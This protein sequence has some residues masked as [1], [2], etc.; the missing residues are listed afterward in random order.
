MNGKSIMSFAKGMGAGMVVAGAA[1]VVGKV[2]MNNNKNLAK[3][4]SKAIKAVSDF[5]D[6]VQTIFH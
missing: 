2:M 1:V 5:V 3:G 6:G 4:S